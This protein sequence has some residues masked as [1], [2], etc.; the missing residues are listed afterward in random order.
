M[1]NERAH[2]RENVHV[3]GGCG[4]DELT[5]AERILHRLGHVI[6]SKIGDGD[7]RTAS[8]Q[9]FILQELRRFLGVAIYACVGD[10]HAFALHA[11]RAPG[12]VL[13]HRMGDLL[14]L[15]DGAVQRADRLDIKT[16]GFLQQR[17][18]LCAVFSDNAEVVAAGL[19][20]PTLG[21]FNVVRAKLAETVC[22][23]KH[24]VRR[25]VGNHHLGPVDHRRGHEGQLVFAEIEHV[26]FLHHKTLRS[27][28]RAEEL[29]HEAKRL[30]GCHNRRLRPN[31]KRFG[32]A[33][34]V[35]RLHV[36]DDKI[37]GGLSAIH[38]RDILHP[39]VAEACIGGIHHR[40]FRVLDEI[41][42]VR[43]AAGHHILSLEQINVVVVH[44]HI[45]DIF[46]DFHA[47]PLSMRPRLRNRS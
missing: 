19:T 1:L 17:L 30:R 12:H 3:V 31:G 34:R 28:G 25:I 26:P 6:A 21:I 23:E 42:V 38:R 36:V 45:G 29:L 43:H 5:V 20:V 40:C 32:D 16:G 47:F 9:Q 44:A 14:A 13:L 22:R 33:G 35:I 8:L 7:L 46:R 24:F 4:K 37:I 27:D 10:A 15:Q 11:V 39:Y 18:R 2:E 41:A